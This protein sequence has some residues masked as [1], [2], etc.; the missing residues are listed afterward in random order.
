IED[1]A[2]W[3]LPTA[4]RSG[5]TMAARRS[6]V[7]W[8]L[9]RENRAQ[10]SQPAAD[11]NRVGTAHFSMEKRRCVRNRSRGERAIPSWRETPSWPPPSRGRDPDAGVGQ[12]TAGLDEA[13]DVC[14]WVSLPYM[15]PPPGRGGQEGVFLGSWIG[16]GVRGRERLWC[17]R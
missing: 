17:A 8:R 11:G 12:R 7:M 16:R 9:S 1:S 3:N 14:C 15:V 6:L 4:V 13:S 10:H 5:L 2:P